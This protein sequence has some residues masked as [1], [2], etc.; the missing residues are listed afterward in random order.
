M[1]A[2]TPD[3]AFHSSAT[4]PG[5]I[6]LITE[7]ILDIWSRRRLIRYLVRA[8]LKKRGTDTLF[9]NVW[10]VI[11]PLLLM[12]VYVVMVTVIVQKTDP[13]YPLF[14]FCAILPWKWFTASV[15]DSIG[16]VSGQERL[17]KQLHFPKVVFPVASTVSE[18]AG[19]L[20]G[21]IPLFT[22]MLLFYR[23]RFSPWILLIPA[24]AFVQFFFTLAISFLFSAVNVFYR[25]VAN[26]SRHFLRLW[27]Y[28]SPGLY[29][30]KQ[31][32]K[33]AAQNPIVGQL[34]ALNPF[35][36]FFESYRNVIYNGT[37]PLWGHL[38][39]WL[40]ASLAI[41]ALTLLFFKRT[42]PSFA[43]VL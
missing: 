32:D 7:G 6:G 25:D 29:S 11:D 38:A 9:G 33:I 21:L 1:S 41:G 5:P 19:F 15:T 12:I 37:G 31:V 16:S 28:L 4:R 42:E 10:W 35:A 14:I 36:T 24:V 8:D 27:F 20:F 34:M 23:D 40:L 17:I 2:T 13:D 30:L 3:A 39:G 43:K 26:V 22:L 18:I